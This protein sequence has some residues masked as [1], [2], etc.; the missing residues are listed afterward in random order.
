MR[1][2]VRSALC[3]CASVALFVLAAPRMQAAEPPA[4]VHD[5]GVIAV[6]ELDQIYEQYS[7]AYSQ[8][9]AKG[10]AALYTRDA[11]YL[12]PGRPIQQGRT[13]IQESFARFFQHSRAIGLQLHISFRIM[14]RQVS[15][16][17]AYDVGV[18]TLTTSRDGEEVGRSFGKFVI[19][20][21]P[22]SDGTWRFHVSSHSDLSISDAG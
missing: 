8:L 18:F 20:S 2:P 10:A 19:V 5:P 7:Q 15:G 21:R 17:L 12:Q 14:A 11:L 22:D 6:P 13:P 4:L 3:L 9:N 1:F 16:D